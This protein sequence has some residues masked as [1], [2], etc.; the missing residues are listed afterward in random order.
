M[1]ATL[2]ISVSILLWSCIHEIE[3]V[4]SS[5]YKIYGDNLYSRIEGFYET[6]NGFMLYGSTQKNYA[7]GSFLNS[8]LEIPT[9]MEVDHLGNVIWEKKFPVSS[10]DVNFPLFQFLIGDTLEVTH[11]GIKDMIP[12]ANGNTFAT[13]RSQSPELNNTW[14]PISVLFDP[15]F[16]IIRAYI[17]NDEAQFA[18]EEGPINFPFFAGHELNSSFHIPGSTDILIAHRL[19]SDILPFGTDPLLD[20]VRQFAFSRV[21]QEGDLLWRQRYLNEYDN[22]YRDL[23]FDPDGSIMLVANNEQPNDCNRSLIKRVN[24]DDY[25]NQGNITYLDTPDAWKVP[26]AIEKTGTGYVVMEYY[27]VG[28]GTGQNR[29]IPQSE[30]VDA[31]SLAQVRLVF[32]DREL[33]IYNI[34]EFDEQAEINIQD[35]N[36]LI[37]TDDGNFVAAIAVPGTG[38]QDA[39]T[40]IK[41]SPSGEVLWKFHESRGAVFEIKETQDGGF[42]FVLRTYTSPTSFAR[43]AFV[44]IDRKGRM[45]R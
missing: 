23:T 16:N 5:F 14:E 45:Y 28:D 9:A 21:S 26:V 20:T 32:L 39:S 11:G 15:S 17:P 27:L 2:F 18:L 12:L 10:F 42:A 19:S 37:A 7:S 44:K 43:W 31:T 36:K 30:T 13:F 8:S 22:W 34:I 35:G 25:T 6:P 29:C 1:R 38:F 41:V 40:I 24:L 3:P 4:H 33:S